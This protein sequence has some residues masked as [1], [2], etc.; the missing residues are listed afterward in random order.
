MAILTMCLLPHA[1]RLP[2]GQLADADMSPRRR[3][4]L[5]RGLQ[6]LAIG[7][8]AGIAGLL[9]AEW[10]RLD[11]SPIP[12]KLSEEDELYGLR[13]QN[14]LAPARKSLETEW[15][16]LRRRRP[17][18]EETIDAFRVVWRLR[19]AIDEA[20]A[21]AEAQRWDELGAVLPASSTPLFERAATV[22]ATSA[23]L[24]PQ[25]R[26]AI[27]WEWGACGWRQCGAQADV[28]QALA[29]LRANLGMIVPLEALFYLDVAKRGADEI[30]AIGVASKM[31]PQSAVG[32]RRYL[33]VESLELI[34]PAEDLSSGD[35]NLP[36]IRGGATEAE[37]ALDDYEA[38]ILG[39]L[40][41]QQPS[42]AE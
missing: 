9:R 13:S 18:A 24:G 4:I 28:S 38:G 27:G 6:A 11:A 40:N 14:E 33:P 17:S 32:S 42:V 39:E 31:L 30:I 19:D 10:L 2:S 7:T 15:R 29:K 20:S 21:L 16:A 22:L 23:A 3:T 35:A 25:E 37:D 26:A 5:N 12:D 41:Q 34:L 36:V 1:F 8:G